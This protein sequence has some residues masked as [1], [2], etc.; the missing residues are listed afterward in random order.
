MKCK[1]IVALSVV[2]LSL[3]AGEQA[4]INKQ[5]Y[6]SQSGSLHKRGKKRNQKPM[7][8]LEELAGIQVPSHQKSRHISPSLRRDRAKARQ[9]LILLDW[10]RKPGSAA[11]KGAVAALLEARINPNMPYTR[12]CGIDFDGSPLC[13]AAQA[14]NTELTNLLLKYNA[15]VNELSVF[16]N[17]KQ[18]LFILPIHAAARARKDESEFEGHYVEVIQSLHA[19]GADV[20]AGGESEKLPFAPIHITALQRAS[21]RSKEEG[22]NVRM[23]TRQSAI[24]SVLSSCRVDFNKLSFSGKN[25]VDLAKKRDNFFLAQILEQEAQRQAVGDGSSAPTYHPVLCEQ[26]STSGQR[27]DRKKNASR[28][29]RKAIRHKYDQ[30]VADHLEETAF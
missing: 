8:S 1:L 5:C 3:Y 11:Q 22:R 17:R 7:P 10:T 16:R 9:E 25:A 13:N 19:Y 15:E 14:G 26:A 23:I 6:G 4:G 27:S 29:R 21:R 12:K 18:K 28:R 30:T 2:G 20:N 24:I